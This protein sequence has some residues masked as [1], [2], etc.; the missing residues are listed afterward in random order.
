MTEDPRPRICFVPQHPQAA[1][2][3]LA[4]HGSLNL[5]KTGSSWTLDAV[6][7]IFGGIMPCSFCFEPDGTPKEWTKDWEVRM[8]KDGTEVP[9]GAWAAYAMGIGIPPEEQ[10][11][12]QS[13]EA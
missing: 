5:M 3:H 6:E 10:M 11:R 2:Y 7:E 4:P 9:V 1:C 13:S 12:V 8:E